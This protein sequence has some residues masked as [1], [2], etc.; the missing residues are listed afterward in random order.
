MKAYLQTQIKEGQG[1]TVPGPINFEDP[2]LFPIYIF[3]NVYKIV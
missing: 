1:S 3:F 2:S